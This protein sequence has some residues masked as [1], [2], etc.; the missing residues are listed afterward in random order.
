MRNTRFDHSLVPENLAT[1]EAVTVIS[2]V[3]LEN[4]AFRSHQGFKA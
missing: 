2:N 1:A 3:A 4:L